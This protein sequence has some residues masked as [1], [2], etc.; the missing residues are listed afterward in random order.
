M[1]LTP[2]INTKTILISSQDLKT[3]NFE[4][5]QDKLVVNGKTIDIEALKEWVFNVEE[6][7]NQLGWTTLLKFVEPQYPKLVRAFYD[8]TNVSKGDNVLNVVLKEVHIELSPEMKVNT[9]SLNYGTLYVIPLV[10]MS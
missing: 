3:R 4:K 10:P 2:Q 6:I 7:F 8:V 9:S 5:W 1:S